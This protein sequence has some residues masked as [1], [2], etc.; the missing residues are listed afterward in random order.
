MKI[1]TKSG[2]K[3]RTSLV[4]GERVYKFD[5][6]VEA[7]GTVDELSAHVAMLR[8]MLFNVSIN[9]FEEDL[10]AILRTLMT[11]EALLATGKGGEGKV[12]DI[13]AA[14]LEWLE[15]RID[16][17]SA[18]LPPITSFTIPGGHVI[19]SQTH[20][21]RTVCRRAEREACHASFE[22]DISVNSL[23]YL[24]RLSDYFYVL[25]RKLSE[26]LNTTETLWIP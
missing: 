18:S 3:G 21:C 23:K 14:N 10:T 19:V 2:D 7:Y 24:N 20:I 17:I 4:G 5:A 26:R 8:D 15:G 9:E 25:G 11:L 12:T 16:D 1:Y 13:T 6:R 22:N